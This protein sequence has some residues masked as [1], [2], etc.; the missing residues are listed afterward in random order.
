MWWVDDIFFDLFMDL[1]DYT[2]ETNIFK[3]IKQHEN[4]LF[5]ILSIVV[6]AEG[7]TFWILKEFHIGAVS[8]RA[9]RD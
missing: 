8:T 2:K 3:N 5:D 9:M 7:E 4:D 6:Q 1:L